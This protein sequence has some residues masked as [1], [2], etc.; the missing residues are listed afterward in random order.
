MYYEVHSENIAARSHAPQI[1]K[2]LH[3]FALHGRDGAPVG[4]EA[5]AAEVLPLFGEDLMILEATGDGDYR[6]LHFGREIVRYSGATRLGQLVSGMR[7]QVARF[8]I[9]SFDQALAEDRALY[10]VHR[11]TETVRVALWERLILPATARDGRRFIIAFSRPLQFREDLLNAVLD[12]SPCG[13][14]ALR[15]IRDERGGIEQVVIVTANHRAAT[16]GGRPDIDLLDTDGRESLPFLSDPLIWQRCVYAMSFQRADMLETSFTQG[17]KTL[18][19]R[20][21]IAPLGDGLLLTLTDITDL[22]VANQTLQSR[23]ATLALEIGRERA[24]RR[25]LSEEID[26]RE[27]REREL[28]RL[29][30]TDPLTALLNRRSFTEKANAAIAASEANGSEIALIIVDLDHFKQVNDSYGHPAGDAV[31]RA[32]ADLLL[33]QFRT[34]HNLVGR[35]GGEEFGILLPGCD[36]A[37]AAASA[38][39]IQDALLIR[40]MPVSETLALHV[41]ASLGIAA[42]H[43]GEALASLTARADQALYRAKNDGR[44]RLGL[45]AP[46]AV[47]AAA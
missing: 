20:I 12:S 33:G 40:S 31:I 46:N 44:N 39:Q 8:S 16:L 1:A 7:P 4:Y 28:R 23:A 29:A 3:R 47:A 30:E 5:F 43:P 42:R 35:F 19:L 17:G 11:S 9:D 22:T 6:W 41:T 25:A 27:E 18:W 34:E 13:I 14:V 10:T 26:Q 45:A 37:A 21:A 36:L 38:R 32:F 24:T 15:A 2:I